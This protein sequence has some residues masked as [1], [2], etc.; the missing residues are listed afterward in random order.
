M[1][2][3]PADAQ[4]GEGVGIAPE[5]LY[6]NFTNTTSG[7]IVTLQG[8]LM[9][10]DELFTIPLATEGLT[11]EGLWQLAQQQCAD[12]GMEVGSP[13]FFEQWA[14]VVSGGLYIGVP[15]THPFEDYVL[16]RGATPTPAITQTH[17]HAHTHTATPSI[18]LSNT[19]THTSTPSVKNSQA[20]GTS[21]SSAPSTTNGTSGTTSSSSSPPTSSA[22][23]ASSYP[24][25]ST[26]T[27]TASTTPMSTSNGG[28]NHPSSS[29]T[30]STN[31]SSNTTSEGLQSVASGKASG[32][33]VSNT[34]AS[35][36]HTSGNG[37][38]SAGFSNAISGNTSVPVGTNSG[39]STSNNAT[40]F[41]NSSLSHNMSRATSEMV[42]S[43]S[44]PS[45]AG[46]PASQSA[47]SVASMSSSSA[48]NASSV[49]DNNS[50]AAES[51]SNS[52]SAVGSMAPPSGSTSAVSAGGRLFGAM[53]AS[54]E[55]PAAATS[56]STSSD[57]PVTSFRFTTATVIGGRYAVVDDQNGPKGVFEWV[58]GREAN[59]S[60]WQW[61]GPGSTSSSQLNGTCLSLALAKQETYTAGNTPENTR[62]SMAPYYPVN[63]WGAAAS[64]GD[65]GP[66][67][68]IGTSANTAGLI[69]LSAEVA[70]VNSRK[71][72]RLRTHSS[73]VSRL[74]APG[75]I[76][77][78]TGGY[79]STFPPI[80]TFFD[81]VVGSDSM[82]VQ[83]IVNGSS[84][85]NPTV[86]ETTLLIPNTVFKNVMCVRQRCNVEDDCS[87]RNG[88]RIAASVGG[89]VVYRNN[90]L[91]YPC[92]CV[93]PPGYIGHSCSHT[94]TASATL[95][96]TP[97][98]SRT[99]SLSVSPTSSISATLSTSISVVSASDSASVLS[100]M[101]STLVETNSPPTTPTL[102]LR[103]TV[104]EKATQTTSHFSTITVAETATINPPPTDSITLSQ[105][106]LVSVSLE[107][108]S[109]RTQPITET[110]IVTTTRTR[111]E[112]F[113]VPMTDTVSLQR[114]MIQNLTQMFID[115]GHYPKEH[116]NS[117]VGG[118]VV[119]VP[120]GP[121]S[122]VDKIVGGHTMYPVGFSAGASQVVA[123][124]A[125]RPFNI[126]PFPTRAPVAASTARRLMADSSANSFMASS[127]GVSSNAHS[128]AVQSSSSSSHT[129]SSNESTTTVTTSSASSTTDVA[130]TTPTNSTTTT[131]TPTAPTTT[132][133]AAT[134]STTTVT[135]TPTTATTTA[136]TAATTPTT[137]TSTSGLNTYNN[138][139][140]WIL[141][142]FPVAP[143][144][145]PVG[146]EIPL[147]MR[148]HVTA[149]SESQQPN[150]NGFERILVD[151]NAIDRR[152]DDT[153]TERVYY[154]DS[155]QTYER[156]PSEVALV[157]EAVKAYQL[158]GWREYTYSIGIA[159]NW[160]H[161]AVWMRPIEG[162]RIDIDEQVD[163]G[164]RKVDLGYCIKDTPNVPF[165]FQLAQLTV[166]ADS[167]TADQVGDVITKAGAILSA[168]GAPGL[169][170]LA[171]LSLMRCAT[172]NQRKMGNI[173]MLSPAALDDTIRGAFGGTLLLMLG[174]IAVQL[175][176]CV[177]SKAF[178][179]MFPINQRAFAKE[180]DEEGYLIE[181]TADHLRFGTALPPK[182]KY[183][184][185]VRERTKKTL[186]QM[187]MFWVKTPETAG[188]DDQLLKVKTDDPLRPEN[189]PFYQ[190]LLK[191]KREEE[192]RYKS[193]HV[194]A[195]EGDEGDFTI[196]V[197]RLRDP[198]RAREEEP[199]RMVDPAL[200]LHG[201]EEVRKLAQP[202]PDE[203]S[204]LEDVLE[205]KMKR[206]DY[207]RA[208]RKDL[209]RKRRQ[210]RDER[211]RQRRLRSARHRV[212]RQR[213]LPCSETSEDTDGV[214]EQ[215]TEEEDV[216]DS[217]RD[218]GGLKIH[219]SVNVTSSSQRNWWG[220]VVDNSRSRIPE[221]PF[222]PFKHSRVGLPYHG[223]W[224]GAMAYV[225]FPSITFIIG[226]SLLQ[227]FLFSTVKLL[228]GD[229]YELY[230][231]PS[232]E[233]DQFLGFL[234]LLISAIF[235]IVICAVP[236]LCSTRTFY[237]IVYANHHKL[238]D[239]MFMQIAET[240]PL[241]A[242][243]QAPEAAVTQKSVATEH[244]KPNGKLVT[245][246]FP[247]RVPAIVTYLFLPVGVV[248]P[249]EDRR[250]FGPV[251]GYRYWHWVWTLTPFWSPF[252]MA[253]GSAMPL[254]D[255]TSC[256][257][258]LSFMSAAQFL[259]AFMY[260]YC[261]PLRIRAL[262]IL[263]GVSTA[264]I[265]TLIAL[266]A[267]A[268]DP[269]FSQT[270]TITSAIIILS[271]AQFATSGVRLIVA[272]H[273]A[274]LFE[275]ILT[276]AYLKVDWKYEAPLSDWRERVSNRYV[277]VVH[278]VNDSFFHARRSINAMKEA[279]K[280]WRRARRRGA[281]PSGMW[282]TEGLDPATLDGQM[283][284]LDDALLDAHE[285]EMDDMP[286][287]EQEWANRRY[288]A[289][290][291]A[292]PALETA[293][294]EH[295]KVEDHMERE[296]MK[297]SRRRERASA[298]SSA[299]VE[300]LLEEGGL[301]FGGDIEVPTHDDKSLET[302][303]ESFDEALLEELLSRS[304]YRSQ[305]T[306]DVHDLHHDEMEDD[307]D[308]P[309]VENADGKD[310]HRIAV[311]ANM[312]SAINLP[313]EDE[314]DVGE[315]PLR[316][317]LTA[318][319]AE[320]SG[321]S[322]TAS[323]IR[324]PSYSK[325][326]LDP[327]A[328]PIA[329]LTH[330][331][332]RSPPF[333]YKP[334]MLD[335]IP[336]TQSFAFGS[337]S[338]STQQAS[339]RSEPNPLVLSGGSEMQLLPPGGATSPKSMLSSETRSSSNPEAIRARLQSFLQDYAPHKV[340]K[341]DAIMEA[342]A[343]NEKAMFEKLEKKYASG[344]HGAATPADSPLSDP[345]QAHV[346]HKEEDGETAVP[347]EGSPETPVEAKKSKSDKLEKKSKARKSDEPSQTPADEEPRKLEKRAKSK[348][349]V[350][351]EEV[352]PV[353]NDPLE[354]KSKS[355]RK[356]KG[357]IEKAVA[358]SPLEA[359]VTAYL[360]KHAP[361]KTSKA[362]SLVEK[363]AGR[364]GELMADLKKKYGGSSAT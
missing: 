121:S 313:F 344:K 26:S 16:V 95:S 48:S 147:L 211:R 308:G 187:M 23:N 176:T 243:G 122:Y 86:N 272:L 245:A 25:A 149:I 69:I 345:S 207:L 233:V 28:P 87:G 231:S 106:A 259:V 192:T 54:S 331:P 360:L 68:P 195:A 162:Y 58:S 27:S 330:F 292:L 55:G 164:V 251:I 139:D 65:N 335:D 347:A 141:T 198:S 145:V 287:P 35:S 333:T 80:N 9:L 204:D 297:E 263:S 295:G 290:Y 173:R 239:A 264:L 115:S 312:H 97:S 197:G 59:V 111:G 223:T 84:S 166:R 337:G 181:R 215:S 117:I 250:L 252:I 22:M 60:L 92:L 49:L 46:G 306:F 260:L 104:T 244:S 210:R 182:L 29:S 220:G 356:G 6:A 363:Y 172:P 228:S 144:I 75:S 294:N 45:Q 302:T 286:S 339:H 194:S 160:T 340:S 157:D 5:V 98:P 79:N 219:P 170:S 354:R 212:R 112:T 298:I 165:V 270:G 44:A 342:Y 276:N 293:F 189:D 66:A 232:L 338:V 209:R 90:S 358:S 328:S 280:D 130:S 196:L 319:P 281:I 132:T 114:C 257:G 359:E 326:G 361:E 216:A 200:V 227:G 8:V 246:G 222:N 85:D 102:T 174:V 94:M 78:G 57:A 180:W 140:F 124:T 327:T 151:S 301:P 315:Q 100:S 52:T 127:S 199:K 282:D 242:P 156:D 213:G 303:E 248:L 36:S 275:Y 240:V 152:W 230:N 348:K 81:S 120:L 99:G 123:G 184:L 159:I 107:V 205:R 20:S 168:F 33:S 296:R 128:S 91:Q 299:P 14:L 53:A 234:G 169:Q 135:T 305:R 133:V 103:P 119:R 142:P 72:L 317:G 364:E 314:V 108:T 77:L 268:L 256:T 110:A 336:I 258:M 254:R 126:N 17:T 30:T 353:G 236:A 261:A 62:C 118:T 31:P 11:V 185:L 188:F 177:C 179:H 21:S 3:V 137:T 47:P 7:E 183:Q 105:T 10:N 101:T 70:T 191:Q 266:A 202:D 288:A 193:H 349:V 113:T 277:R 237:E 2:M 278:A 203:D 214:S 178:M 51:H 247:V 241:G 4:G 61:A 362:R 64:N 155:R 311:Y 357:G 346:S 138:T 304:T 125:I 34:S 148:F 167:N 146:T 42:S 116:P 229:S 334:F 161:M 39:S 134:N 273:P 355:M 271:I 158:D 325:G 238:Q 109:T 63:Y 300:P 309:D 96:P 249:N 255:R 154:S 318:K 274:V 67:S 307:G 129:S 320:G 131:A 56:T 153:S 83:S 74:V 186:L 283:N 224:I 279:F 171:V 150:P 73:S 19:T 13:R 88:S 323:P 71:V 76:R 201:G 310:D 163:I 208:R 93:C 226:S 218:F 284:A 267:A 82:G 235:L 1:A 269:S 89:S 289:Q 41:S 38:S 316:R 12:A 50:Q 43:N 190:Y 175:I 321:T 351:E 285:V 343:G 221:H 322:N 37:S 352:S 15:V 350:K 265:A 324:S 332:T 206:E 18:E 291:A 253:L 136:T 225:W 329:A 262:N 24:S 143:T 341:V 40:S 32:M 217:G